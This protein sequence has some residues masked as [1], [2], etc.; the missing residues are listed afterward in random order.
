MDKLFQLFAQLALLRIGPQDLPSS[1]VLEQ[2]VI[3]AY[4]CCGLLVSLLARDSF[5]NALLAASV[6]TGLLLLLAHLLLKAA[7]KQ[8]RRCQTVTA[9]AGAGM[10]ITLLSAPIVAL[11]SFGSGSANDVLS[12]LLLGL[13]LWN[14]TLIGHIL[15]HALEIPIIAGIVIAMMYMYLSLFTIRLLLPESQ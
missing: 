10:L 2:R 14:I 5:G 3:F 4:F 7:G 15:R 6:D 1:R 8:P 11:F 9:L 12:I 13:A